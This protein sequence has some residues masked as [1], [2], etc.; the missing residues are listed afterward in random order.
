[1]SKTPRALS[2]RYGASSISDQDSTQNLESRAIPF[3][4][5]LRLST[6]GPIRRNVKILIKDIFYKTPSRSPNLQKGPRE[7]LVSFQILIWD[8]DR[9]QV[10]W[11]VLEREQVCKLLELKYDWEFA[12]EYFYNP[13]P[14]HL[15]PLLYIKRM[16]PKLALASAWH[17]TSPW[18]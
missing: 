2:S 10:L 1:M 4:L 9:L 8:S 16:S 18:R 5:H 13:L 14:C 17:P 12:F 11:S 6:S 3:H 7:M 15:N